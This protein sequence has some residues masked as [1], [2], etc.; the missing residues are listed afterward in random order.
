MDANLLKK[1]PEKNMVF[2]GFRYGR[3]SFQEST[4]LTISD[5]YFGSSQQTLNNTATAGWGEL[6]GGLRVKVWKGFWM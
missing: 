2:M 1:D 3:S 4:T 6:V 5:P